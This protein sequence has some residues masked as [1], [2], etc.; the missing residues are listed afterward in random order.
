[1]YCLDFS[2]APAA[3]KL[4]KAGMIDAKSVD[5]TGLSGKEPAALDEAWNLLGLGGTE[6]WR[7]WKRVLSGNE[8]Q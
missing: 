7:T 5:V 8:I 4:T 2:E 1:M 6:W 3:R